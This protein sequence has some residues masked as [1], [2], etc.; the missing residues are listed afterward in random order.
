MSYSVPDGTHPIGAAF[1]R[2]GPLHAQLRGD[3]ELAVLDVREARSFAQGHIALSSH[4][5]LSFLE[6]AA[7]RVLPRKSVPVVVVDE[8]GGDRARIA[9]EKLIA[10]GFPQVRILEGGVQAWSAA[11]HAISTGY[12]TVVKAFADLAHDRLGTPTIP[13]GELERRLQA[14]RPTTV[15]DCRPAHEY[16]QLSIAGARNAPGVELLHHDFD[17]HPDPDHLW[18]ISCFSRTRGIVGT[19]S[20]AR[21]AHRGKV[22]FLEDGIMAAVLH[23]LPTQ[24]GAADGL[25]A[26]RLSRDAAQH[27][28]AG[29]IARHGLR[30]IDRAGY[31]TLKAQ[32]AGRSLYVF[33]VRP[34]SR[35]AQG[36]LAGAVSAPGGQLLMTCD[37]QIPVRRARIVLVDDDDLLRASVTAFWLSHV[38]DA[39]IHILRDA[40]KDF[41]ATPSPPAL[42]ADVDGIEPA[43]LEE[44]LA[45]GAVEVFDVGPS[46]AY[47]QG[48]IP[49]A[50]FI[51][52]AQAQAWF[53]A[54]RPTRPIV[55]TSPDGANAAYAAQEA[56]R[57]FGVPAS[58]LK[59]GTQAWSAAGLPIAT[60]HAPDQRL[61]PFDDD[62]GSPMRVRT[63]REAPFREYL[64]WERALGHRIA[65]DDTVAFRWPSLSAA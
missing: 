11:G 54:H 31:E 65:D 32:A 14:G 5:S 20:L 56:S 9:R 17:A 52:R 18:V 3:E 58:A 60:D 2:A 19:T 41:T 37:L 13:P 49:G 21:L 62:W 27:L 47:E 43:A 15:V 35:H 34:E 8:N 48:H 63:A 45:A 50:R 22:A 33:D 46:L 10:L 64:E 51:L 28:A 23:G 59:G 26:P 42:P 7:A 53:E 30:V 40:E 36:H 4:Q 29:I 38:T 6:P 24:P 12:N 61:S 25:P 55:F 44:R 39:E 16:R 57:A 1:V